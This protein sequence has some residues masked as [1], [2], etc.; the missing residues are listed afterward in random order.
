MR[1][2]LSKLPMSM[3]V[4]WG[5]FIVVD[6]VFFCAVFYVTYHFLTKFW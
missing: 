5:L 3:V 6:A 2:L 1:D 4:F